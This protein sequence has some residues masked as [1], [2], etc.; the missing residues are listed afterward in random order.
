MICQ[1]ACRDIAG[2]SGAGVHNIPMTRKAERRAVGGDIHRGPTNVDKI[3]DIPRLDEDVWKALRSDW[4]DERIAHARAVLNGRLPE[5]LKRW[6]PVVG[7]APSGIQLRKMKTRWGS[8]TP[9]TGRI[10]LNLELAFLPDRLLEYVLVHE[11]THLWEHGHGE[12][13][14]RRMDRYLPEWRRLR[15]ELNRTVR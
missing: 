6:V 2:R 12:G 10:R 11:L 8:C 15:R 4:S 7:R 5:L 1:P 14:R 3:G 9:S 13:F